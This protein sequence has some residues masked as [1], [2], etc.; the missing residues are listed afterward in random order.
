M[1]AVVSR[2]KSAHVTVDGEETGR[3]KNGLLGL[4]GVQKGDTEDDLNYIT[5]KTAGLRI[6]P[7]DGK[8][9]R[10]V[11]DTG[12]G[13][14][15]VSQFTLLGDVRKG[16]RPDF[17]AAAGAAEAEDM[18]EKCVE[19]FREMGIDTQTGRFGAYMDVVSVG[20]GPVTILL[21]SKKRF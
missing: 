11:L 8:M 10:S 15:V 17:A 4:L 7:E 5:S 14:L 3:I 20:D 9:A 2:V 1:I 12:G 6:F 19:A 16:R 18:Y 13:V 21:D